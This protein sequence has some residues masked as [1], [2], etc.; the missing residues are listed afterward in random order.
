MPRRRAPKFSRLK[1][2]EWDVYVGV[3]KGTTEYKVARPAP[4]E[5]KERYAC[6]VIPFGFSP[7]SSG[8]K[9]DAVSISRA[10]VKFITAFGSV[11][12]ATFGIETTESATNATKEGFYPALVTISLIGANTTP[13][14]QKSQ[15][16]GRTYKKHKT[17]S[18]S[19]PFGRRATNLPAD[20]VTGGTLS[21]TDDVDYK[22][23]EKAI[24]ATLRAVSAA[25]SGSEVQTLSFEAEVWQPTA[26]ALPW[27]STLTEPGSITTF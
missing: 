21:A 9:H 11:S 26:T 4:A 15:L 2:S 17:R 27:L 5:D 20:A 25:P 14:D 3:K 8:N 18:A 1:A 12:N 23:M 16:T 24:A 10:G 22:D 13:T 19:I 7:P 6:G